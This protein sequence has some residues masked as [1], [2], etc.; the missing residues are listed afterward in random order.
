MYD[1][2][3]IFEPFGRASNVANAGFPG[4]GMGL[5][6]ESAEGA[7]PFAGAPRLAQPD[8]APLH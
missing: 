3:T 5:S 6:F 2:K 1:E 4:F 7:A 8:R